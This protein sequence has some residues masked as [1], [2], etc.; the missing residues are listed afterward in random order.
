MPDRY[1]PLR[2]SGPE[3]R[4]IAAIGGAGAR[5]PVRPSSA[6]L[7][8][9]ARQAGIVVLQLALDALANQYENFKRI[10]QSV[11]NAREVTALKK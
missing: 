9:G 6:R 8:G 2:R 4:R 5:L 7:G 3:G 11:V 1:A 10:D